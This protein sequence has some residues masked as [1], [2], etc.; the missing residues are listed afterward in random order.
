MNGQLSSLLQLVGSC[1]AQG[2]RTQVGT[3]LPQSLC[4]WGRP[5]LA[6]QWPGHIHRRDPP[7]EPCGSRVPGQMHARIVAQVCTMYPVRP[8]PQGHTA[9]TH[10]RHISHTEKCSPQTAP[11]HHTA[12]HG[13]L[14]PNSI[15]NNSIPSTAGPDPTLCCGSPRPRLL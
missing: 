3:L 11:Q 5:H 14:A 9:A 13:T 8:M 6:A 12:L 10:P 1:L 4:P 7:T 2:W 15:P